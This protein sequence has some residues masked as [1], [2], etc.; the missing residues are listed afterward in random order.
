MFHY[1]FIMGAQNRWCWQM[2]LC[3]ASV[4]VHEAAAVLE[5][6]KWGGGGQQR[7]PEGWSGLPVAWK[8]AAGHWAIFGRILE[9]VNNPV[10]HHSLVGVLRYV[11][12][13]RATG[14][15]TYVEI[16]RSWRVARAPITVIRDP[17]CG[18]W[19]SPMCPCL[20]ESVSSGLGPTPLLSSFLLPTVN[21]LLFLLYPSLGGGDGVLTS[22]IWRISSC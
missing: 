21:I 20:G 4:L 19:S 18:N 7:S 14:S 8:G 13:V 12:A 1:E 15:E 11:L 2:T 10:L 9:Q 22:V 6:T 3:T 17:H 16:G 5:G